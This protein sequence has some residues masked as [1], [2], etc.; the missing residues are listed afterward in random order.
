MKEKLDTRSKLLY[1]T[2]VVGFVA[3]WV[4]T[5]WGFNLPPQGVIDNTVIVVLGQAMTYSAAAFGV[6]KFIDYKI[7]RK[8]RTRQ[9]EEAD[10]TGD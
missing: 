6:D 8:K 5:F 7:D 9:E 2:A 4:I 3:G 10:E 1:G